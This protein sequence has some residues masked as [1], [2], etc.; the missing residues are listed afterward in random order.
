MKRKRTGVGQGARRTESF[1][2]IKQ[3]YINSVNR[4][5]RRAAMGTMTATRGFAGNYGVTSNE[6]KVQDIAVT[7]YQVN[8]TGDFVLIHIP[9]LGTDY[10]ARI[11]RKTHVKSVYIRG[12]I[13][14]EPSLQVPA[15]PISTVTQ[16]A[17]FILF[18]DSQPN[19]AEPAVTDLLNTATPASQLNLNNRDRFRIIKDKVYTFGPIK[20]IDTA[21]QAYA[22]STGMQSAGFKCYKKLN[23][24]T[25]FNGTNGGTIA[26]ITSGALYM[27][28]IGS[29]AA[30]TGDVNAIVSSRVRFIDT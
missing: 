10:T 30:G 1:K 4:R 23:L 18:V 24:E 17:R 15:A 20:V 9:Q 3:N 5:N 28:W 29:A 2:R 22:W 26:D 12:F 25:I 13:A 14:T 7:T 8:T 6:R 19:G 27:F 11:G 16:Q 21:T